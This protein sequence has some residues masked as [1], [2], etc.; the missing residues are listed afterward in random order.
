MGTAAI[1]DFSTEEIQTVNSTL[2][3]R[4][5]KRLKHNW[6]IRLRLVVVI[7]EMQRDLSWLKLSVSMGKT[8]WISSLLSFSLI[9]Y[10]GCSRV[11]SLVAN[12][13]DCSIQDA[14]RTRGSIF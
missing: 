7:I 11:R 10:L 6:P 12:Q 9:R 2:F 5:K 14:C 13:N 4:F 8:R 3:E 1:P